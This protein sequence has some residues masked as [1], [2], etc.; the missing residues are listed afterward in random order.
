MIVCCT[1][2]TSPMLLLLSFNLT[3]TN[4]LL[5]LSSGSSALTPQIASSCTSR[6]N[7]LHLLPD[8]FLYHTHLAVTKTHSYLDIEISDV[9]RWNSNCIRI[10]NEANST[11]GFLRGNLY[12][13]P[14]LPVKETAYMGLVR[15]SLEYCSSV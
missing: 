6:A 3:W 8:Y 9:L 12:N 10:S 7:A 13:C 11:L 4:C 5:S 14:P 15:P 1:F 2:N